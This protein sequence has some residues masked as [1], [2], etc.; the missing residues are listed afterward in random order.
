MSSGRIGRLDLWLAIS[1]LSTII[2]ACSPH[3]SA[4]EQSITTT[5]GPLS[6]ERVEV[7]DTFPPGCE[8]QEPYCQ[9]VEPGYKV[10]TIWLNSST[11]PSEVHLEK[12]KGIYVT[13]ADGQ[14]TNKFAGGMLNRRLLVSFTPLQEAKDFVLHW[15]DNPPIPLPE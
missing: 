12:I 14:R 8:K 4:P 9:S 6:I 11:D 2:W 1:A 10:L 7:G 5:F 3:P 15:P 13:S